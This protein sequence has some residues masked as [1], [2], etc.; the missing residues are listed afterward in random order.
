ML[1]QA[2]FFEVVQLYLMLACVD[3]IYVN[4]GL[5]FVEGWHT[6]REEIR[7]ISIVVNLFLVY[8]KK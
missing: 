3:K 8:L 5:K 4:W 1:L 7:E 2:H 6:F